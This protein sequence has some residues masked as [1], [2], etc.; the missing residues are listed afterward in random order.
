MVKRAL[1]WI[2]RILGIL[3]ILFMM[4]FSL[5][6][7]GENETLKNQLICLF[8]HNI[9]AIICVIVLLIAWKWELIGGV[10]FIFAFFAGTIFFNSFTG[11]WGSLIV[12]SPFLIT[13]ILFIADY[14]LNMNKGA[15]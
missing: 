15:I 13:G 5:D 8:M 11:N 9:P 7:F 2:P 3:A 12:I 4:M 1:Y 14:R 6:C 10:I